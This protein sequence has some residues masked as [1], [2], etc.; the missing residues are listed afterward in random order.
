MIVKTYVVTKY[1]HIFESDGSVAFVSRDDAE[2]VARLAMVGSEDESIEDY[3]LELDT[4][5]PS[6]VPDLL[7]LLGGCDE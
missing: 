3:I 4:V 2:A 7:G 1:P 6:H 5:V